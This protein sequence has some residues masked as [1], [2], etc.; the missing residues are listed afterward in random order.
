[1]RSNAKHGLTIDN[2][3]IYRVSIDVPTVK[4]SAQSPTPPS[5]ADDWTVDSE[6]GH[7]EDKRRSIFVAYM[8][9]KRLAWHSYIMSNKSDFLDLNVR[10][11]LQRH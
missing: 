3:E 6:A 11:M 2:L 10:E 7:K 1:M 9:D 4:E 8:L 5:M